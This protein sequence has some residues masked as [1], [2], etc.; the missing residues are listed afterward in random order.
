MTE[1]LVREETPIEF[2]KEQ[3]EK[4]MEHQRVATSAFT[5]YYLVSLLTRCVAGDPM[6][7]SEPGYD[8]TPLALVYARAMEA[9]RRER[10]RLLQ[11]LG[12]TALFVS[13]FFAESLSGKLADLGYYRALG[14]RAYGRLSREDSHPAGFGPAVFSE[15]ADRFS[16][17][18]DLLQEVSEAS[19]LSSTRS[20]LSLYERWLQTGSRRAARLLAQQG[21]SPMD[22]GQP[23]M[24]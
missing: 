18:A 1:R 23:R 19:R 3:L 2:F 21:I 11:T 4:A 17:F 14:G 22:P 15:L 6:P 8:E 9:S 20:I 7:A 13:G 10:A 12:D 24:Q 16:Q 5:E